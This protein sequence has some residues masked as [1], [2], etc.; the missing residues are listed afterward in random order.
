MLAAELG[1]LGW[2]QGDMQLFADPKSLAT[3]P[4]SRVCSMVQDWFKA[5][6]AVSDAGVQERLLFETLKP[7]VG[8]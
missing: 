4:P 3:A 2:T 5:H 7:V 6:L 8:G 1:K